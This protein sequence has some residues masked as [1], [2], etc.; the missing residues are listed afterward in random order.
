MLDRGGPSDLDVED[1]IELDLHGLLGQLHAE[2][3]DPLRRVGR[4][5]EA[6]PVVGDR[7]AGEP[8]IR[9]RIGQV[10]PVA[11]AQPVRKLE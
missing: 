10:C 6:T 3:A 5:E 7:D 4:G 2:R 9:D 11:G 8:D 1:P